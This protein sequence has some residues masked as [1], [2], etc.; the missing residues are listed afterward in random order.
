MLSTQMLAIVLSLLAFE[1]RKTSSQ[2]PY[3]APLNICKKMPTC[4][5]VWGAVRDQ[6]VDTT[7]KEVNV[8]LIIPFLLGTSLGDYYNVRLADQ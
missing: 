6:P 4:H 5:S 1:L 7:D 3:Q 2:S 8:W